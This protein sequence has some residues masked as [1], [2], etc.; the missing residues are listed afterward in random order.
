MKKKVS[1]KAII[2][3]IRDFQ[4]G[5]LTIPQMEEKLR[6]LGVEY[7]HTIMTQWELI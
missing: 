7:P 3:A 1:E 2:Q 4:A 6:E 5:K